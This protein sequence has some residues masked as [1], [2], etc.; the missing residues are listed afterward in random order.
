[1][2]KISLG[3]FKNELVKGQTTKKR[4]VIQLVNTSL[5]MQKRYYSKWLQ[6]LHSNDILKRYSLMERL[7][8]NLSS[9]LKAS[10]SPILSVPKNNRYTL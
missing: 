4:A 5:L 8:L 7:H 10:Y 2:L 3:A 9:S 6:S 1:M